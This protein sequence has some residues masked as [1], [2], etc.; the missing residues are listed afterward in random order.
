M[1]A[2]RAAA[3]AIATTP[4]ITTPAAIAT[5]PAPPAITAAPAATRP[6]PP[7][8]DQTAPFWTK[9]RLRPRRHPQQVRPGRQRRW[10]S[11]PL[12]ALVF[13]L[14]HMKPF[15]ECGAGTAILGDNGIWL[16]GPD[17]G[18]GVLVS[19]FDPVCDSGLEVWHAGEG[20]SADALSRDLGKQ[21]FD[22]IEPGRGSR[23]EVQGEARVALEPAL[24]WG[25]LVSGV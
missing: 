15:G 12:P 24:D 17:E 5:A 1:A 2:I 6:H 25:R 3:T 14:I 8:I 22:E 9:R 7:V 19:M 21:P 16:G 18:F 11:G 20:A 10:H 13:R 4:A 23:C